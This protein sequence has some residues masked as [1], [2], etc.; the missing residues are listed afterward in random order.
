MEIFN[1]EYIYGNTVFIAYMHAFNYILKYL[2][3]FSCNVL[4]PLPE[5]CHCQRMKFTQIIIMC[6]V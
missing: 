2:L 5:I 3:L 6:Q 1:S 4:R